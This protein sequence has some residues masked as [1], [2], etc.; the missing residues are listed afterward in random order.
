MT[1]HEFLGGI[2]RSVQEAWPNLLDIQVLKTLFPSLYL[3]LVARDT[4][5]IIQTPQPAELQRS[6][7]KVSEHL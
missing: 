6:T 5:I 4:N 7:E 3:A 1:S 2:L